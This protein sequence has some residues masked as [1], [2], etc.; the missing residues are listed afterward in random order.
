MDGNGWKGGIGVGHWKLEIELLDMGKMEKNR[1]Y[2]EWRDVGILAIGGKDKFWN[3]FLNELNEW[4]G[5]WENNGFWIEEGI[6]GGQGKIWAIIQL[7]FVKNEKKLEFE[8]ELFFWMDP[9]KMMSNGKMLL[10][11]I[12]SILDIFLNEWIEWMNG[13]I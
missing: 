7:D 13:G 4:M 9:E 6:W 8:I 12:R 3:I 11:L 5:I 1:K 2:G 10:I